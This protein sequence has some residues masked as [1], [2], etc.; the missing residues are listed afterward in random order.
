MNKKIDLMLIQCR[1]DLLTHPDFSVGQT[2]FLDLLEEVIKQI[3]DLKNGSN[4]STSS[5]SRR[6]R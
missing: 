1:E 2:H 3:E 4:N 6:S 5:D